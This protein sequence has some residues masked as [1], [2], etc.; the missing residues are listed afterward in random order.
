MQEYDI[1]KIPVDSVLTDNQNPNVMT[2]AVMERLSKSLE[3]F[4]N[5]QPI[6]VDA[7]TKIL[8]DGQ[9]RLEAYKA[10]GLK[11]I[12]AILVKFESDGHRRA[13]RQAANKIRGEHDQELD[14]KEYLRIIE[15]GEIE[16]LKIATGLTQGEVSRHVRL[17]GDLDSEKIT[18]EDG[19]EIDESV[20]A[21]YPVSRGDIYRCGDH[22]VMCGDATKDED[23]AKLMGP[24]KADMV[25]IDPP[26]NLDFRGTN[27][28]KFD[29][30]KYDNVGDEEYKQFAEK[31]VKQLKVATTKSC[32]YY[33]AIDFRSYPIWYNQMRAQGIDIV[34]CIVWDKV[35]PGLG[36]KYR[37]Q[38]EFIIYG[39]DR[40]NMLWRGDG[41]ATDVIKVERAPEIQGTS[42][43]LD[44]KGTYIDIG[45]DNF[46]KMQLVSETPKKASVVQGREHYFA[47]KG[48]GSTDVWEGMSMNNFTQRRMEDQTG[49]VHPTM[50][51]IRMICDFIK[52]STADGNVIVDLC[53]GSG[54]TLMAAEQMKR[55]C[56]IME[57]EPRYASL[58]L[59]RWSK[60]TGRKPEKL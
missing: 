48:S 42:I 27:K 33:V 49:I 20:P 11:E 18:T 32:S 16:L 31:I 28:G 2:P 13:Y 12:P 54:T 6:V 38:H 10:K 3:T 17:Y 1:V 8:A 9:H 19:F 55:S 25:F 4:G 36:Q 30:M 52:N 21:V 39:G 15:L 44:K 23:V 46:I 60:F 50:K 41:V 43:P 57:I 58:I 29:E 56:R 34:N 47:I 37:F 7:T 40:E 53:G 59:E 22:I 5:T 35:Y 14:A 45:A 26:Y 51:P 24:V